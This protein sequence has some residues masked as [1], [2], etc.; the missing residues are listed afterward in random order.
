MLDVYLGVM[1][2][3]TLHAWHGLLLLN[4]RCVGKNLKVD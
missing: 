3:K 1:F 2:S 4:C